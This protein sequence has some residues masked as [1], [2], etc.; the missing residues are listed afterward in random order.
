MGKRE[1]NIDMSKISY[2]KK[3][4]AL[5]RQNAKGA[6]YFT[7]I[8]AVVSTSQSYIFAI[9]N[10]LLL[11]ELA[12]ALSAQ[13]TAISLIMPVA[14][15]V[16]INWLLIL[17][18]NL[19]N[20][21][22]SYI[23]AAS[24]M[25]YDLTLQKEFLF[26][27]SALDI[28]FFDNPEMNN[29][30]NQAQKDMKGYVAI[31]ENSV[32]LIL[33]LL[34]FAL[35]LSIILK[36]DWILTIIV[37]VAVFPSFFLNQYIQR[38]NYQLEQKLNGVDRKVS[39][40]SNLFKGKNEAQDIRLS[41]A[42]LSL[43]MNKFE[44]Y[45]IERNQKKLKLHKR[46]SI[47][48]FFFSIF[49]GILN[50]G[51]NLYI[52][53]TIIF[54]KLA[55]G[56][57]SYYTTITGNLRRSIDDSFSCINGIILSIQ[58]AEN[59]E[60]FLKTPN[61]LCIAGARKISNKSVHTVEFKNV[62]FQYPSTPTFALNN[63][64]FCF[65]TN[66]KIAFAGT[67]GAGKT[68]IIKLLLRFYDPTKGEILLDGINIQEY[69][70]NE[71]RKLFSPMFQNYVNYCMTIG[72]NISFN[73][74]GPQT[75]EIISALKIA[76]IQNQTNYSEYI[77]S[78]YSKRFDK[79]GLILS[80]GQAQRL[81]MAR[82]IFRNSAV[83]IFDEPS[84][85]MDA[86]AENEIFEKVFEFTQNKGVILVSHRLSNLKRMNTIFYLSEGALIECGDHK[87]LI[88]QK[89]EYY[90]LYNIQLSGYIS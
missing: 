6:Y 11:N 50:T 60:S 86:K 28:S 42:F 10:R 34:S 74:G 14:K 37:I 67:N 41:N 39:Y 30:A 55:I 35:A 18:Y 3:A 85:S 20:K 27:L 73:E 80:P 45:S 40:F 62:F 25:K 24:I 2:I 70:I 19:V 43:L 75:D 16:I 66:E 4:F 53:Y 79:N 7:F 87:Q 81:N 65:L 49:H 29:K 61:Q 26:K 1:G 9:I 84:A 68:T 31:F 89:G 23:S 48:D 32:K 15:L 44:L 78:E 69:D 33:S 88:A 76:G 90:N 83:Y 5:V 12:V 36:F 8:G 46:N 72:E 38:V 63:L 17:A 13:E 71:Y 77:Q 47:I 58:R 51:I 59:Y 21:I 52:L 57:F 56:D 64:N 82:A 54:Q 22:I